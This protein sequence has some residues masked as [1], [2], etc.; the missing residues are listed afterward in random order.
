MERG[1]LG[2]AIVLKISQSLNDIAYIIMTNKLREE[3][4]E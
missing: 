1:G 2:V 3:E 4:E